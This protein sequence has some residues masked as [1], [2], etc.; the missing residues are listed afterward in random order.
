MP[1]LVCDK[2]IDE[3]VEYYTLVGLPD[4]PR[5]ELSDD[6]LYG[7]KHDVSDLPSGYYSVMASACNSWGCSLPSPL[8]FTVLE[9]PSQPVGFRIL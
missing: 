5:V 7:F 1:Y 9:T 6:P 2:P 4:D 3:A 8:D